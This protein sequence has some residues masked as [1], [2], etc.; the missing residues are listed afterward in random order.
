MRQGGVLFLQR[1][2]GGRG[3][4]LP[5]YLLGQNVVCSTA[6]NAESTKAAPLG[7]QVV[8]NPLWVVKTRLQTQ[9]MHLQWRRKQGAMYKG[10]FNTL[11]RMSREEG[12][13]GLYR[14]VARPIGAR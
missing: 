2:G 11:L 6:G 12:L 4:G 14:R 1:G 7:V 10:A 13:L 8:T 9:H 3:D 5:I